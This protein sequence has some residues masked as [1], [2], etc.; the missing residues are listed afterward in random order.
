MLPCK[1]EL[2]PSSHIPYDCLT[3]SSLAGLYKGPPSGLQLIILFLLC[4]V[5]TRFVR[6][7]PLSL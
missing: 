3:K 4:K 5:T 2:E 6:F 1:V 7:G